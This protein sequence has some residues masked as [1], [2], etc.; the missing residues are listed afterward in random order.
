M[1]A[2]PVQRK[3]SDKTFLPVSVRAAVPPVVVMHTYRLSVLPRDRDRL[4]HELTAMP[5]AFLS[6]NNSSACYYI[7]ASPEVPKFLSVINALNIS[8]T[9]VSVA[10]LRKQ[11]SK[12]NNYKVSGNWKLIALV[13]RV[14]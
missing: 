3:I 11:Y 8:C 5:G 2:L 9:S 4:L 6:D 7:I 13:L 12:R 1:S 14:D 10:E